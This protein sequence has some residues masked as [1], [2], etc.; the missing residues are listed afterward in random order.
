[1]PTHPVT[2]RVPILPPL[3]KH[4]PDAGLADKAKAFGTWVQST[5]PVRAIMHWNESRGGLLAGGMAYAA[6]FSFFAALWVFFSIAG[7]VL[8]NRPDLIELVIDYLGDSIPG[9][10]GPGGVITE[11]TLLNM[12]A[13]M[14]IAGIIALASTLWTA[15]NFLNGARVSV[16][17]VFGLP[18][19]PETN[20]VVTKLRD[21]GLVLLFGLLMVL[22]AAITA[23]SSGLI[24]W[25]IRD[26]LSID[27]GP[28]LGFLIRGGSIVVGVLFDAVIFALILRIMCQV[29]IPA[30]F[31]WPGAIIGGVLTQL[32]K[33][34]G[35]L[36]LGGASS[37]PLLATFAALLG[38]LIFFNFAC[39]VLLIT[40]SWV[41]TTMDDHHV[42][43]RLLTAEEAEEITRVTE[44]EARKERLATESIRILDELER[45]PRWRRRGLRRDY[46]RIV[47]E[48][49]RIERAELR[50]RLG[51]ADDDG[52]ADAEGRSAEAKRR[53]KRSDD[54]ETSSFRSAQAEGEAS[55]TETAPAATRSDR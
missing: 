31:L 45:T 13:T 9:L 42:S 49:Q 36:L 32:L 24:T 27:L 51:L 16:R 35:S 52:P 55:E 11:E 20:F 33:Q 39:M 40:A 44:R 5:R 37:N 19:A 10:I 34:A 14:T 12:S 28:G 48:Q 53:A 50:E 1:M 46:E 21:L 3:P 8:S 54:G 17:A 26:L 2:T 4:G 15:L 23:A 47:A 29:R 38:I 22:S 6:L 30:R 25:V 43:P 18:P 41:K 7:I